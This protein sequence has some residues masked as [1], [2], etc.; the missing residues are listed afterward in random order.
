MAALWRRTWPSLVCL[1][2]AVWIVLTPRLHRVADSDDLIPVMASLYRW[3]PFFYEQDRFGMLVPFLV[4]PIGHPLY[5]YYV[6]LGIA[7]LATLL[8]LVLLVRLALGH[9]ER[10]EVGL[11][12]GALFLALCPEMMQGRLMAVQC[13]YPV[14]MALGLGALCLLI[15]HPDAVGWQRALGSGLLLALSSWV[16]LAGVV[17]L[18]VVTLVLVRRH[19]LAWRRLLLIGLLLVAAFW[20]G[21]SLRLLAPERQGYA[22]F[23][24]SGQW[25]PSISLSLSRLRLALD[26]WTIYLTVSSMAAIL[27][28]WALGR[29]SP[30]AAGLRL[31]G[32]GLLYGVF[33]SITTYVADQQN[34]PRYLLPALLLIVAGNG[35]LVAG[36]AFAVLRGRSAIKRVAVALAIGGM[37]GALLFRYQLP[38]PARVRRHYEQLLGD[39]A[40]A[41]VEVPCT[42][43]VG[44]FYRAWPLVLYA[45]TLIYESGADSVVWGV[46]QLSGGLEPY[47]SAVP[48]STA[49]I[50]I[51]RAD[52]E[53]Y[54]QLRFLVRQGFDRIEQRG[55]IWVVRQ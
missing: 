31:Y 35:A 17:W 12:A 41:I 24:P 47:W 38:S 21:D 54:E 48:R 19:G 40:R 42:H 50:A 3:T 4:Q 52:A 53:A 10:P 16:N 29:P 55:P 9:S 20:I 45:N 49:L 14:S 43:V 7:V 44:S 34:H 25:L 37:A 18:A 1:A 27:M 36:A 11:A 46:S 13:P 51:D 22:T 28:A 32:G 30:I 8:V 23:L 33:V 6:Q 26:G 2:A 39:T 5:N 15:E